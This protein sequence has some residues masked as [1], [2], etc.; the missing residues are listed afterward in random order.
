M[1]S[2]VVA[3]VQ[4]YYNISNFQIDKSVRFVQTVTGY[5]GE[6]CSDR[7]L[8]ELSMTELSMLLLKI[9]RLWWGYQNYKN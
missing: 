4:S 8:T 3:Q 7:P 5:S 2:T 9:K 6:Q 1:H